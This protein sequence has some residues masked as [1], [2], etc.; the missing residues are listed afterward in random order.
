MD[1]IDPPSVPHEPESILDTKELCT[2]HQ[3]WREVL[4]KWLDRPEEGST[5]GNISTIKKQFPSF[6]FSDSCLESDY[7]AYFLRTKTFSQ[8]GGNVRTRVL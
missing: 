8:G 7:L 5:W 4:V 6:V 2:R 1:M 3:V